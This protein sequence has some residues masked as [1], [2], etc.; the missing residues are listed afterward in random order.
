[1]DVARSKN[2]EMS[3]VAISQVL[4]VEEDIWS[5]TYGIKGKLDASITAVIENQEAPFGNRGQV[6]KTVI[7]GPMPF[8]IKT[9][10]KGTRE[11]QYRAQ[12]ML[13]TLLMSERYGYEVGEG[14]LYY[15]Q[16]D[17]PMKVTA[18]RNEV[19]ALIVA[20]NDMV[21][22][23]E[24]KAS[25]LAREAELGEF[26]PTDEHLPQC[27]EEEYDCERCYGLDTCMLY[28]RVG[29]ELRCM[30]P[31]RLILVLFRQWN[32]LKIP[33]PQ[34]TDCTRRKRA[35]LPTPS[36]SFSASGNP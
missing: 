18:S 36:A 4:D 15:T 24:K 2:N 31:V 27:I 11:I 26:K 20:R 12:T 7:S 1:V 17:E 28:R 5:P 29:R 32:A 10:E 16:S 23:M 30:R 13:Y 6:K 34:S 35:T 14:L 9:G 8:E 19:Q 21:H 25:H 22:H 3:L 33:L